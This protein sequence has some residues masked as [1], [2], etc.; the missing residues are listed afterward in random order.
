MANTFTKSPKSIWTHRRRFFVVA[1]NDTNRYFEQGGDTL[2][3]MA[4]WDAYDSSPTAIA[5]SYAGTSPYIVPINCYLASYEAIGY[6]NTANDRPF[7]IE[8]YYGSPTL[9]ALGTTSL[10][11]AAVTNGSTSNDA[12]RINERLYEDWGS[13]ISLS[14][15]DIVLPMVKSNYDGTN[16]IQGGITILFKE[17]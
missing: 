6:S 1:S 15:G 17:R 2:D 10:T 11:L 14:K 8:V 5:G 9:E 4:R 3:S 13:T 16:S 7:Q 12:R